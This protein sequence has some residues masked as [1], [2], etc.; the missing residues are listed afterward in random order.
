VW[1]LVR[2]FPQPYHL[3][4]SSR[5]QQRSVRAKGNVTY[6]AV[7]PPG[8]LFV[9][10]D[11][12]DNSADSRV[13]VNEGGVGLLPVDNLVGRV[14]AIA[15]ASGSAARGF[16]KLFGPDAPRLAGRAAVAC[17]G[18]TCAA[19]ARSAGLRVDAVA[20]GGL[21]ELISALESALSKGGPL[22]PP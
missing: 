2:Y 5:S 9:M 8:H 3:I 20:G 4:I 7:V 13:P 16:A 11:N 6:Q 19:A 15:F 1:L 14:D 12:R 10:G 17:M 22:R 21:P 18:R